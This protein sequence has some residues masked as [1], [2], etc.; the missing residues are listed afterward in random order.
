[1]S[2]EID[3]PEV[4]ERARRELTKQASVMKRYRPDSVEQKAVHAETKGY[5]RALLENG[6]VSPEAHKLLDDGMKAELYVPSLSDKQYVA[7]LE[8]SPVMKILKDAMEANR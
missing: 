3:N 7:M 4:L 8:R 1:M 5:M 2:I 6:L